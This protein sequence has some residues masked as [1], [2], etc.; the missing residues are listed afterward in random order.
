VRHSC[1]PEVVSC[2][3]AVT[4]QHC[5]HLCQYLAFDH[6]VA[7]RRDTGNCIQFRFQPW[8]RGWMDQ[9]E[10]GS[11]PPGYGSGPKGIRTAGAPSLPE[12]YEGNF[13]SENSGVVPRRV[14]RIACCIVDDCGRKRRSFCVY[15][16]RRRCLLRVSVQTDPNS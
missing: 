10:W 7:T 8:E 16:T 11:Q 1:D 9:L 2:L 3:N 4:A 12:P 5:S 14:L 6:T 15:L 13:G